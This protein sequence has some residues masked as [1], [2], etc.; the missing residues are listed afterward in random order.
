[1]NYELTEEQRIIK[2]AAHRF[3]AEAC[4]TD[5]V[6]EMAEDEKGF[7]TELWK[8]MADL[9]WMGLP[10]PEAYGGAGMSFFDL[11]IILTEMGYFCVPGPFFS[12]VVLGGL[13]VLE[14]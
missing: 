3:L 2:E 6:R 1:M 14:A 10:F 5:F 7:T 8:K 13:A 4:S 9:G 12:S 11:A